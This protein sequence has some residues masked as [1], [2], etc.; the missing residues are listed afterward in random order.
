MNFFSSPN[1]SIRIATLTE[2]LDWAAG[3]QPDSCFVE[4]PMIQRGFVWK[5]LQI[6]ELWDT[7]FR[8]LP[9]GA[10]LV[11]EL[12]NDAK[13]IP[14]IPQQKGN[15]QETNRDVPRLGLVDGQQRTLAMLAGWPLPKGTEY[16][17][18]IWVD[19]S[20]T[21]RDS[22]ILR[23]RITTR[24]QPFGFA[25]DNPNA[26]LSQVERRKAQKD[27]LR[28][29]TKPDLQQAALT[30]DHVSDQ[31]SAIADFLNTQPYSAQQSLPID[32]RELVSWWRDHKGDRQAWQTKVLDHL[33][34]IK[35]PGINDNIWESLNEKKQ[36]QAK[37][38]VDDLANG[39]ERLRA[40]EI[41]L[42]RV[43]DSLFVTSPI[44]QTEPPLA[45]LF[46]RLGSNFTKLS[47]ED[48]VY[49][50]LKQLLPQVHNMVTTLHGHRYGEVARPSVASLL[51]SADLAMSALRLATA[52]WNSDGK[53][54]SADPED[55]SKDDFHR[56]IR[57]EKFLEDTF[58][59][60][61][62]D[63]KMKLWFDQ[64]LGYLEY[65]ASDSPDTGLPHHALPHLSRPLVQVLL[66]L[67]Q[68]DY[69]GR[70]LD[71]G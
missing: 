32:L 67:A 28:H 40:A 45:L 1:K 8:G 70:I 62:T 26:K 27:W 35:A 48:Y 34:N 16:P 57:Q 22:E 53:E 19:F 4:L 36:D 14:L 25:R 56:L 41:P 65:R 43:D 37:K 61:L 30:G 23:L 49:A 47:N 11:T 17:L 44:D 29:I 60:L 68:I 63:E 31:A 71:F 18:R 46:K 69:T 20:D 13:S 5:P 33:K 42:V 55:P 51:T 52:Q 54:K 15:S 7:L 3:K 59:P 39:M 38:Y 9:I 66:R 24:N 6:I 21:P 64:V 58:L 50:V 10:L 12:R 2:W